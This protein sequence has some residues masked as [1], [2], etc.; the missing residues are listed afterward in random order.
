MA[1]KQPTTPKSA[2]RPPLGGP[3]TRRNMYILDEVWDEFEAHATKR[4]VSASELVRRAMKA[5]LAA[6]QRNEARKAS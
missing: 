3:S 5:Y 2:P 1:T 6:L 4:N